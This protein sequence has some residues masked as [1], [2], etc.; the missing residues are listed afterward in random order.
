MFCFQCQETFKGSGCTAGGVC[1]KKQDVAELQDKLIYALKGYAF[2]NQ[3]AEK[4]K[5]FNKNAGFHIMECLFSTITNVNFDSGYFTSKISETA[6]YNNLLIQKI[7][8]HEEFKRAGGTFVFPKACTMTFNELMDEE[9]GV[10]FEQDVN[11]R[12]LKETLTY[13]LKGIAAYGMHARILGM[14]KESVNAFLQKALAALLSSENNLQYW[15][16]LVLECGGIGVEVMELLDHA[17]TS[18]Y[19]N[20]EPTTVGTRVGK[21]PGILVSGHDLKDLH[22]LLE[23]TKGTGIDVYT[24]GEMLPAHAYPFF[25][26]YDNLIGNY[27]SAWWQQRDD[28][29][30]FNGPVLMT[31]NCLVP[32]LKEYSDRIYTT[33]MVGFPGLKNIAAGEN[34]EK[35]FSILIDHAKKCAPPQEIESIDLKIGFAH[36]AALSAAEDIIKAIRSGSIQKFVVMAGC[37]GR[38]KEREYYSDFAAALPQSSVILTA[39]CAKYRYNK[40]DLGTVPGTSVPRLMDAGQCNDSYSLIV[41]ALQLAEAFGFENINDLPIVYNIAWYEQKAVLVLL[42]LL[43]LGVRNIVLGPTLP[44]FL[45]ADVFDVLADTFNIRGKTSVEND[46]RLL[47]GK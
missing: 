21:R 22:M 34:G 42:A 15:I 37:D 32:P 45:S 17:N 12:S 4:Y 9:V 14:E 16:D 10:L 36:H 29:K 27:G 2:L 30:T 23:Q 19:G 33:N 8:E 41:I 25:K 26:R 6:S 5:C 43:H 7:R 28:F 35:D 1:G 3:E 39:G 13:G 44:A 20:P 18:A 46:T 38:H 31:T 24:H 47:I 11:I 40:Q